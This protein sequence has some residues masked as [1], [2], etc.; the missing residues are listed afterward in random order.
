MKKALDFTIN[1]LGELY[2]SLLVN[3]YQI[4]NFIDFLQN[5]PEGKICVLKHDVDKDIKAALEIAKIERELGISASYYFRYPQTF[6]RDILK[7]INNFG[8]EIGY[9]Y[10]VLAKAKGDYGQAIRIF[11]KE[12]EEFRKIVTVK[13][14]CAHGSP[15]SKCDNRKLWDKYNFAEF[16]IIGEAYLSPNFNEVLY[17]SDT[18]RCW[19][20]RKANIRDRVK[21]KFNYTFNDTYKFISEINNNTLPNKIMLNIHPNRW[22]DN[23]VLWTG[24]LIGQN[25]KNL[26]K[27]LFIRK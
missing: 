17:L 14:I 15:L 3:C 4:V 23:L 24:E 25:V 21:T 19:N 12:L 13:T 26:L 20:C 27:Q 22:K 1:A 8:H 5:N 18:G 11:K 7:K 16:E 9:H 6:D 2:Q 10:E